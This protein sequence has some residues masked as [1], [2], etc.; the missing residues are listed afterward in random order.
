MVIQPTANTNILQ[1]SRVVSL[2]YS[3]GKLALPVNRNVV[4]FSRFKH[5]RGVPSPEDGEGLPLASLKAL[6][7]IIDRLVN[8]KST[9]YYRTDVTGLAKPEIDFLVRRY[10]TELHRTL[11]NGVGQT[12]AGGPSNDLGLTLNIVA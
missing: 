4:L 11:Q 8:I 9:R 10:Q 6:D 1:L 3:G 2:K 7:S 5:V 12:S